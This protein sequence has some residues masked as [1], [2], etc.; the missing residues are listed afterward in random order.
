MKTSRKT[1]ASRGPTAPSWWA[2]PPCGHG[3]RFVK[4]KVREHPAKAVQRAESKYVKATA[5]YHFRMA[6]Q[7]HPKCPATPFPGCG[8]G[9]RLKK[10]YQ[11][12]A[13]EAVKDRAAGAAK[14]TAAATKRPG[15]KAVGFVKRHPVGVVLALACV[16]LL[17]MM[18]SC[19]SS[20]VTLGKRRGGRGGRDYLPIPG[21]GMLAAEAGLCGNG[22]GAPGLPGQ[23]RKHP[24]L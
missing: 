4:R 20:L 9:N 3:S 2:R 12:R 14:K 23:L 16:L 22:G 5:D 15:Q 6:A 11:K 21:R 7:E 24:R 13:R 18:Q 17:F 19:S 1:W 8:A 10:Q